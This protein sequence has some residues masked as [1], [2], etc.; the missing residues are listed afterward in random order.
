MP[1]S[2]SSLVYQQALDVIAAA[3]SASYTASPWHYDLMT[4]TGTKGGAHLRY[5]VAVRQTT[6]INLDK[7]RAGGALN[8]E[9]RVGVR[10]LAKLR[11]DNMT[12]DYKTGLDASTTVIETL[13]TGAYGGAG[14]EGPQ[15]WR[16]LQTQ[17]R[18]IAD[19]A[20]LLIEQTYQ[21]WHQE[22]QSL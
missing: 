9:S 4:T 16:W 11:P 5:G 22:S 10:I 19:G 14:A 13:I 20:Y 12:A 2:K 3:L 21:V 6:P 7:Q 1:A 18:A 17:S 15:T 8:V